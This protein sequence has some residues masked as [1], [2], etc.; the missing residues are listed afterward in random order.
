MGLILGL[1]RAVPL[2][3]WAVVAALAY[4]GWQHHRA[5]ANEKRAAAAQVQAAQQSAAREA[6]SKAR[7]QEQR[8]AEAIQNVA[9]AYGQRLAQKGVAAAGARAG[10]GQ[11][12][13]T[14][15]AA[16]SCAAQDAATAGR[17]DAARAVGELFGACAAALQDVA[18]EADRLE[19]KL[20]A[21]QQYERERQRLQAAP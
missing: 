2:A 19:A 16:P 18:A 4:G 21:L 9:T 14:I 15:A 10:L 20:T 6:E 17:V 11:L 12:R 7:A 8:N 1:L 5:T 13:D 3:A